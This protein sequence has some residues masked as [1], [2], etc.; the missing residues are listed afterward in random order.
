M[1]TLSGAQKAAVLLLSM[2]KEKSAAVLR[3]L[4]EAEVEALMTEITKLG[5]VDS[6]IVDVVM[7]EFH[8]LA[9][10]RR[11][12]TEGG[13]DF[14][15]GM[16]E[17]SLGT[18]KA[19][20]ILDRL[21]VSVTE[22]PFEFLR[23]ADPRQVL[24][25]LQEEHPQTISLVLAHMA[26]EQAAMVLSALPEEMQSDIALRIATMDR[27]SPE[28]VRQVEQVLERK[29]SSVLQ[30]QDVSQAAGGVQALVDLLSRSDRATEKLI[31]GE[32]EK[33]DAELADQVRSQMFVFE[34]IV[35]LDDRSVQL[36]LRDVDVKELAV[37]LKGV[38]SDVSDKNLKNMSERAAAN[39]SE[40]VELLGPTRMKA[41][42]DAQAGVV[43]VIRQL[44]ESG[45]L[46]LSRGGEEMV[47]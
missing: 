37:A 29:L 35:N 20:A 30:A 40:E 38:R 6:T 25:Y 26:P 14:A 2:G 5:S 8:E 17:E 16:L 13:V 33:R 10:A 44:E 19:H 9:T 46:V 12:I 47:L 42:N 41:V 1:A 31:L 11:Y 36:V 39:L 3:A 28:V 4:P 27:T 7:N 21:A 23:R 18:Q 15:R 45:Q 32:L 24:T 34:D 22:A 43:K